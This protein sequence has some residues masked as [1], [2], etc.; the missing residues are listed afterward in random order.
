MGKRIIPQGKVAFH[1]Y[2]FYTE[3]ITFSTVQGGWQSVLQWQL[4]ALIYKKSKVI[5]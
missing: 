2:Y 4:L 3:L 1:A 5:F